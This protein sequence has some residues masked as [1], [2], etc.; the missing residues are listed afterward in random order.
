MHSLIIFSLLAFMVL[1][2]FPNTDACTSLDGRHFLRSISGDED[3]GS[4]ECPIGCEACCF[5]GCI[6]DEEA[7]NCRCLHK[8]KNSWNV[9]RN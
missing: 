5:D 4:D 6:C 1:H 9:G 2:L 3:G 7:K 8:A